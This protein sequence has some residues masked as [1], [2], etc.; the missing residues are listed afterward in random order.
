MRHHAF[1]PRFNIVERNIL[2]QIGIQNQGSLPVCSTNRVRRIANVDRRNTAQGN[3][4]SFRRVQRQV[5]ELINTL[6]I[7][8]TKRQSNS[9]LAEVAAKLPQLLT[10]HRDTD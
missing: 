8:F 2:F 3:S 9:D 4:P 7:V 1:D 6:L 5:D 10:S